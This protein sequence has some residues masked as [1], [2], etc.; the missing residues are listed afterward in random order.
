MALYHKLTGSSMG[1]N[2]VNLGRTLEEP[3]VLEQSSPTTDTTSVLNTT[4]E[5]FTGMGVFTVPMSPWLV[6]HVWYL[7]L[8][9]T[10]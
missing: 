10:T 5:H 8:A 4:Y 3:G 9:S 7:L 1:T 2:P 6:L